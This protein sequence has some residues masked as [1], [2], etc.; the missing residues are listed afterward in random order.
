[1]VRRH[2]TYDLTT[3]YDLFPGEAHRRQRK[4]MTPIFSTEQMRAFV[5]VFH[6]VSRHVSSVLPPCAYLTIQ[7]L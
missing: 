1:M 3:T 6:E 2:R 5:P 4:A 7:L